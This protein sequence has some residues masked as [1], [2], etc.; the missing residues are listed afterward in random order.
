M[1]C[2]DSTG[3]HGT[4]NGDSGGPLLL[5]D[6]P[7]DYSSYVQIGVTSFGAND[8]CDSERPDV[9]ARLTSFLDLI[10]ERT[11]YDV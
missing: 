11:G 4:C 7:G 5:Q 6:A 1:I 2:I 10:A 8:G 3:Q 9:F